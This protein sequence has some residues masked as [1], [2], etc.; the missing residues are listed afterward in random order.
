MSQLVL[1]E[2]RGGGSLRQL[3]ALHPQ[4]G[5]GERKADSPLLPPPAAWD[6]RSWNG[7][8]NQDRSFISVNL[9]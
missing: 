8:H 6:S 2:N 5:T 4:S 3:L 7:T 1:M 9:I